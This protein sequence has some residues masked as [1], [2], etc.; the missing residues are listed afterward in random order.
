MPPTA[1]IDADLAP[2]SMPDYNTY[3]VIETNAI[4]VTTNLFEAGAASWTQVH[5]GTYNGE[6][7]TFLRISCGQR[8][9]NVYASAYSSGGNLYVLRSQNLGASWTHTYVTSVAAGA[10]CDLEYIDDKDIEW[11]EADY[12]IDTDGGS[13][14]RN[15]IVFKLTADHVLGTSQKYLNIKFRSDENN[16]DDVILAQAGTEQY[17]ASAVP[18]MTINATGAA[19]PPDTTYNLISRMSDVMH[20]YDMNDSAY[21]CVRTQSTNFKEGK[22][23]IE[24]IG[25]NYPTKTGTYVQLWTPDSCAAEVATSALDVAP[26]N[27]TYA[28][29]ATDTRIYQT[30]DGNVTW[31]TWYDASG[32]YDLLVDP[33]AA[34]AVYFIDTLG[35]VMLQ[36]GTPKVIEDLSLTETPVDIPLRLAREINGG[37]LWCL[38]HNGSDSFTLME[39]ELGVWSTMVSSVSEGR[40]LK[41]YLGGGGYELV[42]L[43][44]TEVWYKHETG[45][46]L[47]KVGTWSTYA[48]PKTINLKRW[49]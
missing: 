30:R 38:Q 46:F 12:S 32:A 19:I 39:R 40:S 36:Y 9:G 8:N 17:V 31:H 24:E 29:V 47:P 7:L 6:T 15:W 11:A 20:G 26:T 34:G 4:W 16:P 48:V 2:W 25:Y 3:F 43:D 28:Y 14:G 42:Y 1:P 23:Y 37:R 5:D 18:S 27:N 49:R 35:K 10:L 22:L 21:F 33:Q 13:E 45:A 41:C 44:A